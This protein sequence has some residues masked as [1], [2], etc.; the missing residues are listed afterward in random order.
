MI[1]RH[2][3]RGLIL[4]LGA[5]A[6]AL[7]VAGLSG[8]AQGKSATVGHVSYLR[9]LAWRTPEGGQAAR[10][11]K[12]AAVRQGDTLKTAKGSRLELRLGD[13]SAVRLGAASEIVIDQAD[14]A[15]KDRKVSVRLVL[16]KV[17]SKVTH[18]VDDGSK[19]EVRTGNA[20][21]GVRG[22]TF[23]VNADQDDS[24]LVRVYSG[25]VAVAGVRPIYQQHT[26]GEKR[27]QVQG[28]TQV[29]K[30]EWEKLVGGMMSVRVGAN[31]LPSEVEKFAVADELGSDEADWVAW[32]RERDGE[33]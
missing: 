33:R 15:E 18:A 8:S 30:D 14:F 17:W 21:A 1:T 20:V 28:P 6:L 7:A 32:N 27:R 9:G 10:V 13:G 25:T 12:G 31:G 2:P 24:T 23:R 5:M 26:P 11:R 29:T 3:K 19:F 16:G 4:G 22:T